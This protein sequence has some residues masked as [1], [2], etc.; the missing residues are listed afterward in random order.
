MAHDHAVA[1]IVEKQLDGL[2]FVHALPGFV[3]RD[4]VNRDGR[5]IVVQLEQRF[6]GIVEPDFAIFD[7][8]STNG[9]EPVALWVQPGGLAVEDHES[10]LR[11]RRVVRP[12]ILEV[13]EV[14]GGIHARSTNVEAVSSSSR[15]MEAKAVFITRSSSFPSAE[16]E[17]MDVPARVW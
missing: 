2:G 8:D 14:A 6:K 10:D 11:N 15:R 5:A 16:G 3:A 4:A 12:G 7:R 1:K 13:R 17:M 9:D